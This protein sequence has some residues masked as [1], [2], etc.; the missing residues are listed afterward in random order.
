MTELPHLGRRGFRDWREALSDLAAI[1]A[2]DPPLSCA[3]VW[4]YDPSSGGSART[5]TLTVDAADD[6]AVLRVD[7]AEIA[8]LDRARFRGAW[9]WFAEG[10]YHL[11]LDLGLPDPIQ[12][13]GPGDIPRLDAA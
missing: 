1:A 11:D 8:R 9:L 3:R 6:H 2:A 5:G 12:V 13:S 4:W 7:G 10:R